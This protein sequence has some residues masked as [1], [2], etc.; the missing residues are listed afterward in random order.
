MDLSRGG[1][2]AMRNNELYWSGLNAL[3]M[4]KQ[5]EPASKWS[6][7]HTIHKS[8]QFPPWHMNYTMSSSAFNDISSIQYLHE[9]IVVRKH[10]AYQPVKISTV[11]ERHEAT[12]LPKLG[13]GLLRAE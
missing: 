13:E 8:N 11:T 12:F 9:A 4:L 3:A 2:R 7:F 10:I 6:L 5:K 1:G